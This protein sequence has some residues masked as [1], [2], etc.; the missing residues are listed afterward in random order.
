MKYTFNILLGLFLTV[1]LVGQTIDQEKMDKDLE[2]AENILATLLKQSR[3]DQFVIVG[4]DHDVEAKHISDYGVVLNVSSLGLKI[5]HE[6]VYTDGKN[7]YNWTDSKDEKHAEVEVAEHVDQK[8]EKV[9]KEFL[10]D[11]GDMIRQLKPS[12]KIMVKTEGKR[13][14]NRGYILAFG[15]NKMGIRGLSAE[16][17]KADL[18]AH[19][20]G[21][22]TRDQLLEKIKITENKIDYSKEPQLEVFSSMLE[23]LYEVDLTETYY[24]ANSPDYERMEDF[25]ATYYLKFYSSTVHDKDDYSLPTIS[26]KHV[27]KAERDKLVEEMYPEF[28]REFK[29]NILDYGHI[30]KNLEPSELVVFNI[31]LTSCEGCDMPAAIE[32]SVKKSVIDDYRKETITLDKAMDAIKVMPI[33]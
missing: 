33:D 13:G 30:L 25:G 32:V 7:A 10:A 24:M 18:I 9:F 11:Y 19:D 2:I 17:E 20:D 28:I 21:K 1:S 15:K 14:G 23:R 4:R 6:K 26:R 27:S 8:L 16:V 31:K 3:N 5:L 12:D 22:L 29:K